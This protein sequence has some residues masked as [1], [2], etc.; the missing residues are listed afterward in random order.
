MGGRAGEVM[1]DLLTHPKPSA[2]RHDGLTRREVEILRLIASGFANKQV[3]VR[4]H[5]S[6]KTVRNHVSNIYEK[7]DIGDRSQAVLYA[8]R[9]GLVDI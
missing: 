6:D 2:Q 9:K 7:L 3:A 5:I 1:L 4:L 8:V